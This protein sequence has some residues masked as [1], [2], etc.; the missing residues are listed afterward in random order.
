[1]QLTNTTAKFAE[2]VKLDDAKD[3]L[4][5]LHC[6]EDMYIKSLIQSARGIAE[7]FIDSAIVTQTYRLTLD[8]FSGDI[9]LP[10]N[11]VL[12][13]ESVKY[14][15][16]DAVE[17]T[18]AASAYF[19]QK[20]TYR[21]VLKPAYGTTWPDTDDGFDKVTVDFTVG[22]N[23]IPEDIKSAIK[24]IIHELYWHRANSVEGVTVA[25]VP[26]SAESILR[27]YRRY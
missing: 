18:M 1:M 8:C 26:L 25:S 15:D 3:H 20:G 12:S 21:S 17:T 11:P 2:A 13:V 14:F 9:E 19:V 27:P 5:V 4:R 23:T 6:D 16:P 24:L 7:N 10:V 22:W